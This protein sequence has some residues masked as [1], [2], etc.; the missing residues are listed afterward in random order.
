MD[1][2]KKS[3]YMIFIYNWLPVILTTLFLQFALNSAVA[4][5]G[6]TGLAVCVLSL[7]N[8]TMIALRQDPFKPND[9]LLGGEVLSVSKSFPTNAVR[10]LFIWILVFAAFMTVGFLVLKNKK[11]HPLYRVLGAAAT[12]VLFFLV[13][14]NTLSDKTVYNNLYMTGNFYNQTDN[15]QSKGFL[16]SFLYTFNTSQIT[17]PL[18]YDKNAKE[19]ARISNEF[20]PP[21][22][23]GSFKPNIVLILGE[24]FSDILDSPLMDYSQ[25]VDPLKNFKELASDSISGHI[26]VPNVGGGT[27]D[28]EF[29]IFTGINTRHFRGAPYGYSLIAK[30]TPSF[31]SLLKGL[32]YSSLAMHPGFGWFYNRQNVYVHLGFPGLIDLKEFDDTDMKGLYISEMQTIDR[33]ITEYKTRVNENPETPFFEFVVTIQNHGPYVGKYNVTE[34]NFET[35]AEGLSENHLNAL[36]NYVHGLTDCD[37]E[38][39]NLATFFESRKEPIILIYYG[40]HLPSFENQIYNTFLPVTGDPAQD[41]TRLFKT[42]FLIWQNSAAKETGE[43]EQRLKNIIGEGPIVMSSSYL[44]TFVS[45]LLGFEKADPFFE[46]VSELSKD[47]PI[48][49]ENHYIDDAGSMIEQDDSLDT[50]LSFYKS[51]EYYRI[52]EGQ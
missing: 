31:T 39:G 10:E 35:T 37:V 15:F 30:E 26:V 14:K 8:R 52:F 43:V 41:A 17:K 47:Y 24:A 5:C 32:G 25:H 4:A 21:D 50:P 33:V 20:T 16:Y 11:A 12:L 49:L 1:C 9:I 34:Q 18:N 27:A 28:T 6:I 51:W 2:I 22:L 36:Q 3:D 23:D 45:S 19:I 42:P 46:E 29:D 40:D 13:N 7:V 48:V 38:L 44:G